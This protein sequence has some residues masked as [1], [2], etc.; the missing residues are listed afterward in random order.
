MLLSSGPDQQLPGAGALSRSFP[1]CPLRWPQPPAQWLWYRGT[2]SPRAGR[3]AE[4]PLHEPGTPG[5]HARPLTLHPLPGWMLFPAS[6][7]P[8]NSL[9]TPNLGARVII[10]IFKNLRGGG[11]DQSD[12]LTGPLLNPLAAGSWG[13]PGVREG[14]GY[15]SWVWGRGRR[16]S[17]SGTAPRLSV[18]VTDTSGGH[19][20]QRQPLRSLKQP[21]LTAVFTSPPLIDKL[22]EEE[23]IEGT[24][25]NKEILRLIQFEP[26][27]V[28]EKLKEK[29]P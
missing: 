5:H 28:K 1:D 7:S 10:K 22:T 2:V 9:R 20:G 24:L 25:A 8:R 11:T 17:P 16:R 4:K 6:P 26:R 12:V 13:D 21:I 3:E 19:A 14:A 18:F 29:K 27:K 15:G 23:F